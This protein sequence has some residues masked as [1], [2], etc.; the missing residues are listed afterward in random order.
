MSSD[1]T[2]KVK[3]EGIED[4]KISDIKVNE[5]YDYHKID[6]NLYLGNMTIASTPQLVAANHFERVLSLICSPILQDLKVEGVDYKFVCADDS[7]DFDLLTHFPECIRYIADGVN[8]GQ[9]VYVHCQAGISRSSTIVIAF[10]MSK[11]GITYSEAF[12]LVKS[13]RWV[14]PNEGFVQQLSL[15]EEMQYTLDANN[16]KFRRFL[17]K[18]GL[19][20]QQTL[21][22]YSKSLDSYFQ[23]LSLAETMTRDLRLGQ[24]FECAKCNYGLFNEINI[25]KNESLIRV[26]DSEI[27][28]NSVFIEPQKWMSHLFERRNIA[29]LDN[30]VV[31]CPKCIEEV[32]KIDYFLNVFFCN[33]PLHVRLDSCLILKMNSQK[34][35][36]G[37]KKE[38]SQSR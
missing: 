37:T 30:G 22:L 2:P 17:M 14:S 4:I 33:C 15:F 3:L 11:Y 29:E 20:L 21:G 7:P 31:N 26:K 25:I 6:E 35:G 19:N 1:Q 9:N 18:N 28:C 16:R 13:K 38:N 34:F 24:V 12:T 10:L 36:I 23:K 32:G 8:S 27:A 5:W